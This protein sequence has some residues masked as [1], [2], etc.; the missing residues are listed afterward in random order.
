MTTAP[1]RPRSAGA[2]RSSAPP[3]RPATRR[4]PATG[5]RAYPARLKFGRIVLVLALGVATLKLVIVQTVQAG[6]LA[7]ASE[8]QSMTNVALPAKRGQITDRDGNPLAFSAEARALVTNPRL[9]AATHG[10]GAL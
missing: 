8:R 2:S 6:D 7:A 3:R 1:P 5:A 4:R 9:I 10:A